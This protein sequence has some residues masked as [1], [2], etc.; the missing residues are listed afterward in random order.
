MIPVLVEA[1][2]SLSVQKDSIAALN[3]SMTQQIMA[4][5]QRLDALE[6][7]VGRHKPTSLNGTP[8]TGNLLEQNHPNPFSQSTTIRYQVSEEAQQVGLLITNLQGVEVR[9]FDQLLAGA[10][11]VQITADSLIPGTYVCALIADGLP[12]GS[13]RMILTK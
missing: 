12:I 1:L 3:V 2:K 7:A 9:R 8:A 4:M 5:N 13:H 6:K 11:E 10:G